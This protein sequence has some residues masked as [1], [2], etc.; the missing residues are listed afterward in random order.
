M[1]LISDVDDTPP[2]YF[3]FAAAIAIAIDVYAIIQLRIVS[4]MTPYERMPLAP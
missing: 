4:M 2:F 3:A 1:A